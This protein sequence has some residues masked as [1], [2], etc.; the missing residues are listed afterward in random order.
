MFRFRDAVNQSRVVVSK[1][2]EHSLGGGWAIVFGRRMP[3]DSSSGIPVLLF[4]GNSFPAGRSVL[5]P[6]EYGIRSAI[7]LFISS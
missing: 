6:T 5:L 1:G 3:H 4:L 2:G 7:P